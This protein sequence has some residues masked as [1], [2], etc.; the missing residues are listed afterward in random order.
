MSIDIKIAD[1]NEI[2]TNKVINQLI[3]NDRTNSADAGITRKISV[4]NLLPTF[5][6]LNPGDTNKRSIVGNAQLISTLQSP[7]AE[8]VDTN[9]IR[10]NAIVNSKIAAQSITNDKIVPSTI[11]GT[12][13]NPSSNI[14]VSSLNTTT[15][16]VSNP[17]TF[18]TQ[19]YSWPTSY[20]T[21]KYLRVDGSG[22]LSW[23][24][25]VT[26]SGTTLVYS[27]VVPVGAI[28]PW[29]AVGIP[30][31]YLACD[32][33]T[34]DG[35]IYPS[36]SAVLGDTYGVH[37]GVNYRLPNLKGKIPV[38]IGTNIP[39]IN[40]NVATFTIGQIGGEYYHALTIPEMPTHAHGVIGYAGV[41]SGTQ[42]NQHIDAGVNG[43]STDGTTFVGGGG[44]HNNIQPY[45]VTNYIIKA[46]PDLK[47]DFTLLVGQGLS[48]N[49]LTGNI[50][51]SGGTLKIKVDGTTI[52]FNGSNQLTV[53][54]AN[55]HV[56]STNGYQKLPGGLIIQWG[57]TPAFYAE[58]N[59]II[60]L[61]IPFPNMCLNAT[62]TL[63]QNTP[64][65]YYDQSAQV[66][67]LTRTTIGVFLQVYGSGPNTFP[68]WATWMAIG[69]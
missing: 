25:P 40:G 38:G 33:S 49:T 14:A 41:G 28:M 47:A 67:S 69:F 62:A 42:F 26:G 8:S 43:P 22:N 5:D 23:D 27:D 9:V 32:G 51:L 17:T 16:T 1:L 19:Q 21:N 6:P 13:I 30:D 31:N 59:Q 7:G 55:E 52:G 68:V 66:N 53:S 34:F 56:F 45:L 61:P 11:D 15:L 29:A 60:T 64:S 58:N 46:N 65:I 24:N 50:N 48:A 3:V 39:D 12:R 20:G 54:G 63:L 57:T 36:L 35:T 37:S 4:Q 10:N 44:A 2:P 18:N